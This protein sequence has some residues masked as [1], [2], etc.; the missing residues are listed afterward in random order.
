MIKTFV[1][2]LCYLLFTI[3][4]NAQKRNIIFEDILNIHRIDD[5]ALS[6]DGEWLAFTITIFNNKNQTYDSDIHLVNTMGGS[7]RQLTTSPG[8]DKNPHWSPDGSLLAFISTRDGIP[9]I[10]TLPMYGGEAQK[11][12]DIQTGIIDFIWSHDGNYFAFTSEINSSKLRQDSTILSEIESKDSQIQLKIIDQLPFRHDQIWRNNIRTHLFIMNYTGGIPWDITPGNTNVSTIEQANCRNFSFSPDGS[13]IAFVRKNDNK[14][15]H[16]TNNDIF[17]ISTKGG[18]ATRITR[19]LANDNQPVFSCDGKY[20]AYRS[21][22]RPGFDSDQYDLM[23]YEK[24]TDLITNLTQNFDLD[25]EEIMW[26]P[27]NESIYFTS[28]DQGRIVV[29]EINIKSQKIK[30]LIHTGCN[31]NLMFA[32]DGMHLFLIR[33]HINF[34]NEIFRCNEKGEETFQLTYVN[35]HLLNQLEM[36]NVKDF[37]FPSFDGKIVHGLLLKPPFFDPIKSYPSILLIQEKPHSAW[38]DRFFYQWNTQMFA[39]QGYVVI[40][41][42]SRGSKGY[43]QDFCT[44]SVK[45]WGGE[46]YRDLMAGLDYVNKE[47]S[48]IDQDRIVAAGSFYG[49]YMVNWIAGHTDRFK[50]LISHAGISNLISFYGTTE[51]LGFPEWELDGTPYRN[52]KLYE[53]WSPIRYAKNFVTPTLIIHGEKDFRVPIN[54]GL[55]MFTALQRQDIPSRLLYF[56]DEGI[57]I[58]KSTNALLWWNYIFSWIKQWIK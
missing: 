58:N 2:L 1:F 26:N 29:F 22:K 33:S 38:Q 18:T 42:N 25:I 20:I 54:Q 8:I 49:G 56:P 47:F 7:S 30:G 48:F 6:P 50:C 9:Q 37:W 52:D 51:N 41:I 19:N 3:Q 15:A 21:M 40:M 27:S 4:L 31:T 35:Q 57:S 32:P 55:E 43:G 23:L 17:L 28:E 12:S 53:K 13:E 44:A 36:N 16:S 39:S 46:P 10:Y 24:D 45:N 14:Q 34:P 11:I 5:L